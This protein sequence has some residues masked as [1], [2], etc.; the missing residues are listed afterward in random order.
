MHLIHLALIAAGIVVLI[1]VCLA[2]AK[3]YSKKNREPVRQYNCL[4]IRLNSFREELTGN[5][6]ID[7]QRPTTRPRSEVTGGHTG[8]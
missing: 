4:T 8:P 5:R 2:L 1:F 6:G 3:Y 7:R